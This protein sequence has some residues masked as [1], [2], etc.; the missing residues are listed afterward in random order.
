MGGTD[1][2]ICTFIEHTVTQQQHHQQFTVSS[3]HSGRTSCRIKENP[4]NHLNLK[5]GRELA[6][7]TKI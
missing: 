5:M 4:H 6:P 7:L 2:D 3:S 1:N